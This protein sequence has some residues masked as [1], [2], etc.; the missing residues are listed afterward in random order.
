VALTFISLPV[1]VHA[2]WGL[3][4]LRGRALNAVLGRTAFLM[5]GFGLL[6]ALGVA[7]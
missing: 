5:A 2:T 6:L 4:S 7:L 1:A 3:F